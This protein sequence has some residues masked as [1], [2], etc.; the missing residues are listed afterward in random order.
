MPSVI[1][2]G[3]SSRPP[4]LP[5]TSVVVGLVK[6]CLFSDPLMKPLVLLVWDPR[7]PDCVPVLPL[8]SLER[9]YLVSMLAVMVPVVLIPRVIDGCMSLTLWTLVIP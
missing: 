1:K 7:L 8:E 3:P 2:E 5:P 6:M 9:D 4:I